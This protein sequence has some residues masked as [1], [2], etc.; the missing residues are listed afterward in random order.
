MY[1]RERWARRA[2]KSPL[3]KYA[4]PESSPGQ[5]GLPIPRLNEAGGVSV[6]RPSLE[7]ARGVIAIFGWPSEIS[8]RPSAI[9]K[10]NSMTIRYKL[11]TGLAFSALLLTAVAAV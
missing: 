7:M 11:V 2:V 3:G 5:T 4:P 8:H 1:V 10:G 6:I 9:E